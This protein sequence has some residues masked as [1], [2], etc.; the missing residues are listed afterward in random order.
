MIKKY[1]SVILKLIIILEIF[2]IILLYFLLAYKK[3]DNN[4]FKKYYDNQFYVTKLLKFINYRLK[5]HSPT[6]HS[7]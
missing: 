4:K 6:P 2:Y 5:I 7:T 3:Y 1:I